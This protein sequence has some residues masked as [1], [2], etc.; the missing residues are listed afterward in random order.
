MES[1]AEITTIPFVADALP[2]TNST[3]GIAIVT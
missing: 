2:R 1:F 3:T